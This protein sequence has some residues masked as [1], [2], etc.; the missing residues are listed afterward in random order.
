MGPRICRS[1]IHFVVGWPIHACHPDEV[2]ISIVVGGLPRRDP[3][4]PYSGG[5]PFG[6]SHPASVG[7]PPAGRGPRTQGHTLFDR[8]G[9][10]HRCHPDVSQDPRHVCRDCARD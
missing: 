5:N 2:R 3:T 7:Y 8:R 1:M 6:M 9:F 4:P 10:G